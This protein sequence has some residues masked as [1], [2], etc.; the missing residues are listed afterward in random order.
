[1][2]STVVA[3]WWSGLMSGLWIGLRGVATHNVKPSE[4]RKKKIE[5]T[6]HQKLSV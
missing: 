5:L 2:T 4:T 3:N 1:M 6:A